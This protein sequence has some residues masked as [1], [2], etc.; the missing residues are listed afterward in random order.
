MKIKTVVDRSHDA[1]KSLSSYS[2]ANDSD[3]FESFDIR[4]AEV[5][6]DKAFTDALSAKISEYCV[7]TTFV[8]DY[9]SSSDAGDGR[10]DYYTEKADEQP[11]IC[12]CI[13]K[14]MELYGVICES[15]GVQ[16]FISLDRPEVMI[17]H[18][19]NYGGR[20]YHFYRNKTFKLL[21]K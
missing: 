11:E 2:R 7:H 21:K 3:D 13:V 6:Y 18:P 19:G 14:D 12:N 5:E 15:F 20:N 1:S 16:S 10:D 4:I 8:Y 9:E 17:C